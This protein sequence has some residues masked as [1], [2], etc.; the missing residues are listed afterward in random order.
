MRL[1][2][3]VRYGQ[4]AGPWN[5]FVPILIRFGDSCFMD[6]RKRETVINALKDYFRDRPGIE[7]AFLFGSI[8]KGK[9]TSRSDVDVAVYFAGEYSV[10]DVYEITADLERLLKRDVDLIVLND[11]RASVAW[12][13]LRGVRLFVK[14]PL[15]YIN[16]ML[17]VSREAEDFNRFS[18]EL[19]EL[20]LKR[21][22]QK[23]ARTGG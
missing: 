4:G 14:R 10:A 5:G 6:E 13:A 3:W 18:K 9:A 23:G 16:Y 2:T 12:T 1:C 7:M 22:R 8:V 20:R 19:W 21:R 15:S 17:D 11:A